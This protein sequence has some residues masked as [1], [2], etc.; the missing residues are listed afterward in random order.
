MQTVLQC[1]ASSTAYFASLS[2][3]KCCALPMPS[4]DRRGSTFE[5]PD[6][7][8]T[9]FSENVFYPSPTPSFPLCTRRA[10]QG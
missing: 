6:N 10:D 4:A 7:P 3:R 5:A 2:A 8:E 9:N 1:I